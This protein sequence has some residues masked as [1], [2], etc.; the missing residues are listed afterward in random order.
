MRE[1]T[2]SDCPT[3]MHDAMSDLPNTVRSDPR[4]CL[5][6]TENASPTSCTPLTLKPVPI[7]TSP[8]E[9]NEL[10]DVTEPS[11]VRSFDKDDN[12]VTE[13]LPPTSKSEHALIEDPK[14]RASE[15][16]PLLDTTVQSDTDIYPPTSTFA[17]IF[18][19]PAT[20]N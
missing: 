4:Y 5:A 3:E 20:S 19:L 7:I 6:R 9:L 13:S 12:S 2:N 14:T 10:D 18:V 16:D 15:I 17:Q 11:I 8:A 1:A